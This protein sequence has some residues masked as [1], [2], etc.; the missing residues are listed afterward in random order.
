MKKIFWGTMIFLTL[1]ISAYAAPT[2]IMEDNKRDWALSYF[3]HHINIYGNS[4]FKLGDKWVMSFDITNKAGTSKGVKNFK[5]NSIQ[6]SLTDNYA[7]AFG[8][9]NGKICNEQTSNFHELYGGVVYSQKVGDENTVYAS[10]LKGDK[11]TDWRAGSTFT[12]NDS[13]YID[14]SYRQ[15]IFKNNISIKGLSSGLC[16]KF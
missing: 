14:V 4:V 9:N 15:L 8:Y 5:S 10:Y 12:L 6:Y 11:F 7:L 1:T 3:N 16:F 13:S 2:T